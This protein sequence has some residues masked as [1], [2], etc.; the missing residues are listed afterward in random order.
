MSHVVGAVADPTSAVPAVAAGT[1]LLQLVDGADTGTAIV[2]IAGAAMLAVLSARLLV[3]SVRIRRSAARDRFAVWEYYGY[4][5]AMG[6][7]YGGLVLT[8]AAL[9]TDLRFLDGL[10]LA[11]ATLVAFALRE[12]YFS[13]TLS[14]AERDRIGEFRS[15]RT[16]EVGV[17]LLVVAVTVGPLLQTGWVITVGSAV[18]ATAVVGYGLVYQLRRGEKGRTRGTLLDTLVRQSVP[19]L[20]FAGGALVAPALALGPPSTAVANSVAA[21]FLVATATSLMTVTIKLRQHLGATG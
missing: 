4:A 10:L 19:V 1:H 7:L 21:V 14:N 3:L 8:G 2:T 20:V 9:G 18:G 5:G 13:E 12:A 6:T 16:F 17:V 15:R 11:F